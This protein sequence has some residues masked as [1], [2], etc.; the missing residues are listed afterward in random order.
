MQNLL[1][2]L[3]D[4]NDTDNFINRRILELNGFSGK[5]II[6]KSATQA[7]E[8]FQENCYN[9]SIIPDLLF[10][11]INM[12]VVDGLQFLYKYDELP[13]NVKKKCYLVILSSSESLNDIKKFTEDENVKKYYIKPLKPET[14][15]ALKFSLNWNEHPAAKGAN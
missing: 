1:T 7:L 4:D 6:K 5:I 11:D 14:L 9:L 10:L 3:V 8:Y 15:R 2:M 13:E 12:P